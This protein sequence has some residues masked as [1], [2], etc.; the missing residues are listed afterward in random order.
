MA[1]VSEAEAP[2]PDLRSVLCSPGHCCRALCGEFRRQEHRP[3]LFSSC[4]ANS[5]W[6]SIWG[7]SP[8]MR[9]EA[10]LAV[11]TVLALMFL[12]HW[13]WSLIAEFQAGYWF[14]YLTHWSLTIETAYFCFAAFSAWAARAEHR[15][16]QAEPD[17]EPKD[18]RLPWYVATTWALYHVAMPISLA[19]FF[20]YWTLCNPFWN[21]VMPVTYLTTFVHGVN[22]A[23]CALDLSLSRSLFYIRYF[24]LLFAYICLY[25]L[26]SVV[27]YAARVGT[28]SHCPNYPMDQCPIYG[29]LDWHHPVASGVLV[30]FLVLILA[31]L[32]HCLLWWCVLKRRMLD[33]YVHETQ[34]QVSKFVETQ[35]QDQG[36]KFAQ[37]ELEDC[38]TQEDGSRHDSAEE[39]DLESGGQ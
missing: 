32:L 22:F 37:E 8:W 34:D 12:A 15:A 16:T 5:R 31:P 6:P 38:S 10:Y 13:L 36:S 17:A 2:Q 4:I 35:N 18:T 23:L 26:W 28:G 30:A 20:M 14:I 27:Q 21:L 24:L 9:D 33:S 29:A 11:R 39:S 7:T 3:Q 25:V 19:V 1:A